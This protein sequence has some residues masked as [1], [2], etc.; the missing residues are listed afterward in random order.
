MSETERHGD[1]VSAPGSSGWLPWVLVG[2]LL[3]PLVAAAISILGHPWVP[4]ADFALIDLRSREVASLHPPLTGLLSRRGWNHPGPAMFWLLAPF[5][6]IARSTPVSLRLGWILLDGLILGAALMLA[7]RVS[8]TVLCV[9]A[10]T[11]GLSYLALP[12]SVH[13][14]PWNPW[15]PLPMLILLLVLVVRVGTGRTRD[16]IGV[17]SVGSVMVQIHAGVAPV[18][19]GLTLLA[20]TWATLDARATTNGV[21]SLRGPLLWSAGLGALLWLPP[22]IGALT[23]EP[24]NLRVLVRYFLE[25]PDPPLGLGRAAGIMAAEFAWRP[26]WLGGPSRVQPLFNA[27]L[28]APYVWLL[29][30][31]ALLVGALGLAWREQRRA[32]VRLASIAL[33][34]LGSGLLA[35]SRADVPFPYTFEWRGIVA[36][37][38]VSVLASE[39]AHIAAVHARP[40]VGLVAAVSVVVA[41]LFVALAGSVRL[42]RSYASEELMPK[43][44][45]S[46]VQMVASR[47]GLEGERVLMTRLPDRLAIK[48]VW[49]AMVNELDRRGSDVRVTRQAAQ[50]TG[51]WR[52]GRAR[53]VDQVWSL[54]VGDGDIVEALAQPGARLMWR[55][56]PEDMESGRTAAL[57]ASLRQRLLDAD[58]PELL[59]S[60]GRS[61]VDP[62]VIEVPGIDARSAML[63]AV[64]E[65]IAEQVDPC[66][67]AVVAIPGGRAA[68]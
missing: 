51:A 15:M 58:R 49:W 54:E 66:R 40:R 45:E 7:A 43:S 41:T 59:A 12:A 26:P 44:V 64:Q 14:V 1:G 37:F 23:G 63:L 9:V 60:L 4:T 19:L 18:V 17:V 21:R 29:V 6:S 50:G 8:R 42:S 32:D 24:G 48:A 33:V 31:I 65:A 2:L 47:R 67:C 46:M 27:A 38:A 11:I 20:I 39:T 28:G 52:I 13:R 68:R 62:R 55:A 53:D 10:V 56:R 30:P 57:R 3:T 22:V 25:A 34:M 5:A 35:I 16:L 61:R 36:S